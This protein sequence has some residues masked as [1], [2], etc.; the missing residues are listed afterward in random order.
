MQPA[1]TLCLEGGDY[2]PLQ[3]RVTWLA[4][5]VRRHTV[6]GQRRIFTGLPPLRHA[7]MKL[8]ASP[9]CAP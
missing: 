8:S 3:Q 1:P 9:Y 5:S 6:A 2:E 4:G 7:C